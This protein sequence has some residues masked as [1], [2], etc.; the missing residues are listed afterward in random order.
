MDGNCV[1]TLNSACRLRYTSGD[2]L[3]GSRRVR[4]RP[5]LRA[6]AGKVPAWL[7]L[8]SEPRYKA[9]VAAVLLLFLPLLFPVTTTIA[10]VSSRRC[11]GAFPVA[12][13][14]ILALPI[15]CATSPP[16]LVS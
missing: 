13:K 16:A 8:A 5:W 1:N 12:A 11:R 4:G 6:G 14:P 7:L 3:L 9:Y 10:P 2:L 15:P